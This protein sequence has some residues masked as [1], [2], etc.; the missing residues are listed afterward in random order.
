MAEFIVHGIPGSPYVRAALLALEEK[1]AP[2]RL[3]RL[4]PGE[5][6]GSE[7]LARHPFG[8]I[9]AFEHDGFKLYE[10]QAILRYVDRVAEGLRL[11]PSDPRAEARMNQIMGITD[12]YVMPR[13]SA[14]IVFGRII[15]PAFGMAVD[16]ARIEAAVPDA[17]LCLAE[18]ARLLDGHA[19]MAGERPSLADLLL[20][21]HLSML[22]ET[23]EGGMLLADHDN[24]RDWLARL[25]A[26][27]SMRRT[28]W[29]VLA[30][31]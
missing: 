22:S 17:R 4:R 18:I 19:W 8:R 24:L 16:E 30:A 29:P 20:G 31:G 6:K 3:V 11:T 27:P 26:R 12:W 23:P 2:W 5:T 14:T 28:T 21:P 10:T 9:P 7:H 13:V 25:E 1:G 15:G